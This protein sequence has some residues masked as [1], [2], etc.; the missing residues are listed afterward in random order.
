VPLPDRPRARRLADRFRPGGRGRRFDRDGG[1]D[2]DRQNGRWFRLERQ[3]WIGGREWLDRR[4]V[5][6]D[7]EVGRVGLPVRVDQ[8][9]I[10]RFVDLGCGRFVVPA[11][12]EGHRES[13]PDRGRRAPFLRGQ[14]LRLLE[15]EADDAADRIVADGDPVQCV[16]RLDRA[17][18]VR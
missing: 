3:E 12:P 8:R 10:D 1:R 11:A 14:R 5:V 17:A 15:P 7:A 9:R 18:V 2:L 4:P 6:E 16:G 13:L